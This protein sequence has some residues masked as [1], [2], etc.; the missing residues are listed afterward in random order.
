MGE[1]VIDR[2]T[3]DQLVA[4]L[5]GD[6]VQ[7]L[8]DTYCSETPALIGDL[9]KALGG[10]DAETFRRSAHSIKSSSASVGALGFAEQARELEMIGKAG[11]LSGVGGKVETLAAEYERVQKDLA[12]LTHGA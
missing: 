5:G 4:D 11:D 9:R 8:V 3:F 12:E 2:G 6:F 1:N 7:E 10:Q